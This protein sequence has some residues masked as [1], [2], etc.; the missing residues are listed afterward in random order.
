MDL[1]QSKLDTWKVL[2]TCLGHDFGNL[3]GNGFA[4]TS[5]RKTEVGIFNE[6]RGVVRAALASG[7][8]NALAEFI[9]P[10]CAQIAM[11]SVNRLRRIFMLP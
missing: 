6:Y 8:V 11:T 1:P 7:I 5:G 4:V 3:V 10:A 2:W 9:K